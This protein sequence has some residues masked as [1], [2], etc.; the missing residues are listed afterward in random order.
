MSTLEGYGIDVYCDNPECPRYVNSG[1]LLPATF[2]ARS[3]SAALREAR[4]AGW[5]INTRK[6]LGADEGV[7]GGH[8]AKCG[9]CKAKP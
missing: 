7:A 1:R 2:H 4:A 5:W 3:R 8:P 9:E 6:R